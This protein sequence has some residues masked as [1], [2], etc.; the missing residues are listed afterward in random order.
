MNVG[1]LV[2]LSS[3]GRKIDRVLMQHKQ[4][5]RGPESSYYGLCSED[6][7][8]FNEYWDSGKVVGLVTRIWRNPIQR[9]CWERGSYVNDGDKEKVIYY[10]AWQANPRPLRTEEHPRGHLKFVKRAKKK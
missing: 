2:T 7:K 10:V 9:Y 5:F 8:R 4:Y 1:D 3:A 6:K